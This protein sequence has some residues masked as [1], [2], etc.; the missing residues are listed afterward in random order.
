MSKRS[1]WKS[2]LSESIS[3]IDELLDCL[4]LNES[5]LSASYRAAS[6]FQIRVPRAFVSRMEPGNPKDPLLAQVLPVTDE[7]VSA[8]GFVHDPLNESDCNPVPGLVHKYRHRLLLIV[9]P[10]CAINCRYCFRRHFPYEENKQSKSQWERS[11]AYIQ[12]NPD[13][14]EV[15][16]SGG[17]PLAA[18]DQFL[19]WLTKALANISH[20][21]RL[22]VHTRLPVVIPSRIDRHLLGWMTETRLRPIVVL[23][24]NHSNEVDKHVLNGVQRLRDSGLTILNQSVL[25][26]SVND[27]VEALVNLSETLYECGIAP[28]YLHMLDSVQGAHHFQVSDERALQLYKGMQASLPGYLVPKLVKERAGAASKIMLVP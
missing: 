7:L 23:H 13:I 19:S 1:D 27:S 5:Q 28:Y 6:S 11:L 24:I 10:T 25:L 8:P 2:E 22:R 3:S 15:I 20:V 18:N 16:Y 9:S 4:Q 14:N 17:D 21:K 26:K 12:S